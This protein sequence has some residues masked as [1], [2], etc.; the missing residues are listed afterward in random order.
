[1]STAYY[2]STVPAYDFV[3][4]HLTTCHWRI[5]WPV[6]CTTSKY[7]SVPR[8]HNFHTTRCNIL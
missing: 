8:A 6:A 4:Q 2:I 5:C 7:A 1:M 3:P